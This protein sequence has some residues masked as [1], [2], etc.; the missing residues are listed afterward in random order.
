MGEARNPILELRGLSK[1]YG[2][3][4]A[5]RDIDLDVEEG[6]FI[7]LIGPSG[8][9]KSTILKIVAGTLLPSS[10]SVY[11]RGTNVGDIP[12]RSQSIV[13]LWQSLAL[14]SHSDVSGN[15][16]YGLWC[17][18]V[19]SK[20]RQ[21]RVRL[22][23][24]LVGLAGYDKRRIHELS[25]GEQQRVA[26]ARALAVEPE[27][28]LLDEPL[29]NLDSSLRGQLLAELRHIHQS[30]GTTFVMVTHDQMEA[31]S[32]SARVAVLRE[33]QLEQI[34]TPEQISR[35]PASAFVAKFVGGKNV[36]Q[37]VVE[38]VKGDEVRVAVDEKLLVGKTASWLPSTP[39]P[40]MPVSYVI[41]A[42]RIAVHGN[43][44]NRISGRLDARFVDGG[45]ERLEVFTEGIGLMRCERYASQELPLSLASHD[46]I[47][48]S[49]R[50]EDAYI[51]L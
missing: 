18:G 44:A 16:G 34:G 40:G 24:E 14:F 6:E 19:P 43:G 28:V 45:V 38:S 11:F 42:H 13:M 17:R 21:S 29:G 27:I 37:G 10:G 51:L 3:V 20:E 35:C 41:E 7:S 22:L 31:L 1:R 46:N 39:T 4:L 50:V 12:M 49:W 30:T 9:G 32:T 15:V 23:L 8:S 33:G 2:D 47:E 36:L 26:L 48:L 5:I 25:G